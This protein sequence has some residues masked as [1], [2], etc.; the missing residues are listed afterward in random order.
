MIFQ[1]YDSAKAIGVR[2]VETEIQILIFFPGLAIC[3][4]ILSCDAGQWQQAA[5]PSQACNHEGKQQPIH[6]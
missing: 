6:L 5:T 3:G 2:S 4:M 1:L